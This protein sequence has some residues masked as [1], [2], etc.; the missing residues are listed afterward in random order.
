[1][2]FLKD[3]GLLTQDGVLSSDHS[4]EQT[5]SLVPNKYYVDNAIAT[6][7]DGTKDFSAAESLNVSRYQRE[8]VQLNEIG[9]GAFGIVFTAKHV[10]DGNFYAVKKISFRNKGYQDPL[11]Q[12]AMREVK[13]LALCDH[14]N[15]TRYYA[16]WLEPTWLTNNVDSTNVTFN[17]QT[18]TKR[19]LIRDIHDMVMNYDVSISVNLIG[20]SVAR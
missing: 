1:M 16:A 18:P 19:K 6:L 2:S 9:S 12:N 20:A 15:V 8:F 3:L 4:D 14:P 17:I 13:Y 5:S 11:V 10:V 7:V